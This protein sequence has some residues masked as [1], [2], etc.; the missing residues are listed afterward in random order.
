MIAAGKARQKWLARAGT[1]FT[2][3]GDHLLAKPCIDFDVS[4]SGED[5]GVPGRR[6]ELYEG[7]LADV[8]A[9]EGGLLGGQ[10]KVEQKRVHKLGCVD[11]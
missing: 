10:Q 2:K 8:E 4:V 6:Q 1:K 5:R 7:P 11:I 3:P 9:L